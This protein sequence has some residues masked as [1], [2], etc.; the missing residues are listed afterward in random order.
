MIPYSS[1]VSG[2][3]ID[4]VGTLFG[5]QGNFGQLIGREEFKQ[6]PI[7]ASDLLQEAI[8]PLTEK[9]DRSLGLIPPIKAAL[10]YQ[11][12]RVSEEIQVVVAEVL[13]NLCKS[14]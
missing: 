8:C 11:N 2:Y 7:E 14:H 12:L 9:D 3:E 13:G 5:E 10:R 1:P 4:P 6:R